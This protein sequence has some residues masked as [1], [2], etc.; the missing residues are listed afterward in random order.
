MPKKDSDPPVDWTEDIKEE[1]EE[2][3]AEEEEEEEQACDE[4]EG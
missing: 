4:R 3:A 1:V 2:E